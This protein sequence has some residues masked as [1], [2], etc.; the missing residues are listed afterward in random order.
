MRLRKDS[1]LF[2]ISSIDEEFWLDFQMLRGR[3]EV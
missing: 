1:L 3:G 2:E